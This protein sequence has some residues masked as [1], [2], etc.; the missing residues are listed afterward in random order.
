MIVTLLLLVHIVGDF[1]LQPSTWVHNKEERKLKSLYLYIHVA[2]HGLLTFG[3]L[4]TF[5]Y[6]L[7]QALWISLSILVTHLLIDASKLLLQGNKGKSR[8]KWFFIDQF[9]H[10]LVIAIL[11]LCTEGSLAFLQQLISYKLMIALICVLFLMNPASILID[12]FLSG[13]EKDIKTDK[14][15]ELS[16][17]GKYIGILE[18]LFVFGFIVTDNWEG[19]GFLLAAKS[20]FRFGDLNKTKDRNLTEYILIGT[21]LSFGLAM[22]SGIIYISLL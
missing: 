20:V 11:W 21:L 19:I 13:W 15:E 18:R 17:A 3:I 12:K 2:I 1:F 8:K 4:I 9:F 22:L 16:N 6:E 7:L 5:Q 14:K 10:L